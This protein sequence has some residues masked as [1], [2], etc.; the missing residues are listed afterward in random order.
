MPGLIMKTKREN[1]MGEDGQRVQNSPISFFPFI[2]K[3][4]AVMGAGEEGWIKAGKGDGRGGS[5]TQGYC[6]HWMNLQ[7]LE[8]FHSYEASYSNSAPS[9]RYQRHIKVPGA[10]FIGHVISFWNLTLT[11]GKKKKKNKASAFCGRPPFPPSRLVRSHSRLVY[12]GANCDA[13]SEKI[14]EIKR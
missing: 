1:N 11:N 2:S 4:F 7:N 6:I 13:E 14:R 9:S 8:P 3:N 5:Q 10:A 12:N